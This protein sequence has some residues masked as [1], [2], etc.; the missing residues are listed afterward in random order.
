MKWAKLIILATL[1]TLSSARTKKKTWSSASHSANS[2]QLIQCVDEMREMLEA[3]PK[4]NVPRKTY[5]Y[6]YFPS[7]L[8]LLLSIRQQPAASAV[9]NAQTAGSNSEATKT[10]TRRISGLFDDAKMTFSERPT[11]H[12]TGFFAP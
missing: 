5:I 8:N 11:L 9:I 7:T 4:S 10:C 2:T 6:I 3:R 12:R 1:T